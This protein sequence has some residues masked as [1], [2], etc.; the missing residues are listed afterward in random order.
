M[1]HIFLFLF[2]LVSTTAVTGQQTL[3]SPQ[4]TASPSGLSGDSDP[5]AAQSDQIKLVPAQQNWYVRPSADTRRK[6]YI[7]SIVGPVSI[8]RRVLSA[9]ISTWK[10]S[11][12]EWGTKWEG[13]GRRL[14]SGFATSAIKQTTTFALDEAFELDSRFY[15]S[16]NK[17]V[18]SRIS[19]A[20]ISPV[21]ARD[22][23]GKRV[24]GFPNLT[25]TYTSRIIAYEA[26]YPQRYGWEKA[27]RSGTISL[28]MNAAFNLFKEFVWKK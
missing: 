21:T 23:N 25:G 8:G 16:R 20:L 27:I 11:P 13:F 3:L 26:W 15:R 17:S 5:P 18:G 7:K 14:A 12:E 6:R 10:N 1:K 2:L 19:N 24:F 9:G 28:G 22:K 4:P